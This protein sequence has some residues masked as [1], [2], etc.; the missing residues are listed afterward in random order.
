MC[1]VCETEVYEIWGF[2]IAGCVAATGCNVWEPELRYA[3]YATQLSHTTRLANPQQKMQR[4]QQLLAPIVTVRHESHIFSA[5]DNSATDTINRLLRAG[6]GL[7]TTSL[8][9]DTRHQSY[10]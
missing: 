4:Y 8:F 5:N 2:L 3:E 10:D 7:A 1:R 9:C 6:K